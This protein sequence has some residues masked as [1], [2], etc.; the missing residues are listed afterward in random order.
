M[1][2]YLC[3]LLILLLIPS[4]WACTPRDDDIQDPLTFYYPRARIRYG[5]SDAVIAPEHREAP[6]HPGDTD[7]ILD[8]YL[9]GPAGEAFFSPFPDGVRL[10]GSQRR[11]QTFLVILSDSFAELSGMDLTIACVCITK[12]CLALTG[13]EQVTIMTESRPLNGA[14]SITMDESTLLLYDDTVAQPE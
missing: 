4:L 8:L 13:A 9:L 14:R 12:T 5:D 3:I 1:K 7:S 6:A 11:E 2:K 10:I